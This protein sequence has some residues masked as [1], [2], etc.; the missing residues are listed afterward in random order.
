M[1]LKT[2][3]IC[4]IALVMFYVLNIKLFPNILHIINY[5]IVSCMQQ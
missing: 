5:I 2:K 3:S 1:L 4:I